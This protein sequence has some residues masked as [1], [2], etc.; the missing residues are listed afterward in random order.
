M[1][2]KIREVL[3]VDIEMYGEALDD[4]IIEKQANGDFKENLPFQFKYNGSWLITHKCNQ[5]DESCKYGLDFNRLIS[6]YPKKSFLQTNYLC[7]KY[8]D[9][10]FLSSL[11]LL[12]KQIEYVQNEKGTFIVYK[13]CYD[14][15]FPITSS[16]QPAYY[17][18]GK[19]HSE[20][21]SILRNGFPNSPDNTYPQGLIGTMFIDEIIQ[22]DIESKK[23]FVDLLEEHK[24]KAI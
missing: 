2:S 19:C 22:I 14:P 23:R 3:S 24:I 6:P 12:F 16:I 21:I 15:N 8:Y 10:A 7:S 20:F 18:C 13:D 5:C 11:A 1:I 17:E 9:K 4:K